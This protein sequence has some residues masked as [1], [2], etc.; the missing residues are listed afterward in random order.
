MKTHLLADGLPTSRIAYGCMQLSRAWDAT[1]VSA[2]ERRHAQRLIE[3]ALANGITLFDHA[4]IYARGKSEQV[5]GDV[6][7]ASPGLRERMVLQSKCGIRFA[8]DPPGAPGRYDFSHAHIVGSVEGSLSRLGV[9]HLDLLLLHRPDALVEP[10]DVARAFDALHAAGKVRHFGVSNHTPGQIDLLRRYVRQPLVAH[11]VELSLLHHHLIDDGVVA[12][13][14][15]HAYASAAATL[16]YCRLHDIR[17]Q[18][19]SPLAG[20]RLATTSEFADPVIRATSTLL[21]QLA[22]E[23]GVTPEAVQLAW[24]LRHPAGIQPIVGT[25][26]PVR[27]VACCAADG[28]TLSREEWYALFTAAR[29]D[30]VP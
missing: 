18:A 24:L 13:T 16:D 12:N 30:P 27:L 22:E 14:T 20:G 26:D 4:D 9:D 8:D 25:T 3:T 7:R 21:R 1:P 29:G 11:Q 23:K 17:V 28:I 5:F 19:W 2:D 6:L 15:G 10:E